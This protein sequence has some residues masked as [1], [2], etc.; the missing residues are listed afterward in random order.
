MFSAMT[1]PSTRRRNVV[2]LEDAHKLVARERYTS[3][4]GSCSLSRM[5]AA[6]GSP[7]TKVLQG[8]PIAT[9]ASCR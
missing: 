4:A 5:L 3:C 7:I 1:L 6:A 9:F 8:R 2:W